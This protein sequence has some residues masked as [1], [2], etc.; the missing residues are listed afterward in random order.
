MLNIRSLLLGLLIACALVLV[1]R[2]WMSVRATRSS[3]RTPDPADALRA[4]TPTDIAIGFVTNFFDTLGIGSF[5]TT[6]TLFKLFNLVPDERIPGTMIVGHA[7]PMIVQAFIFIGVI[8]VDPGNLVLLIAGGLLGGWLGAGVVARLSRRPI[9]VGMGLALIVAS[10]FMAM[11]NL[12]LFP[13]GGTAFALSA[14]KL[15]IALVSNIVLGALLT[16]GIGNYGPSLILFSLLGMEPRAAFPIMMG[17]G[18]FVAMLAGT[19]F[20]GRKRY[21]LRAA[22]GL[23]IGGIPGALVAGLIV[24]SLSLTTVRWMVVV[25]VLYTAATMLRAAIL[26]SR[27]ARGTGAAPDESV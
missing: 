19:R 24:K 18:G 26:E 5:A 6:T 25:V 7:L 9:Q 21:H 14:P 2:W 3:G 27:A 20:I 10:V 8:N 1:V 17:S 11:S 23:T 12:G 16:I 22:L 13:G 4:P 15:A